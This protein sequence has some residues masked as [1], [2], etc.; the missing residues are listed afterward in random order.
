MRH[1]IPVAANLTTPFARHTSLQYDGAFTYMINK[2][3]ASSSQYP[4]VALKSICPATLTPV[5]R[6]A[7][8]RKL[9]SNNPGAMVQALQNGPIAVAVTVD[10][11][12]E[13]G[14]GECCHHLP[15]CQMDSMRVAQ[16]ICGMPPACHHA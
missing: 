10:N 13:P 14:C 16:A 12:C 7:S 4:Y 3:L 8:F 6:L 1:A 2:G 9:P 11:S 5:S 15:P